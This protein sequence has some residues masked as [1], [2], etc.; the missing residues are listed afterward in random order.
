MSYVSKKKKTSKKINNK[1]LNLREFLKFSLILKS[2]ITWENVLSSLKFLKFLSFRRLE[3]LPNRCLCAHS[4]STS[5]QC[6]WPG[7]GRPVVLSCRLQF[8]FFALQTAKSNAFLSAKCCFLFLLCFIYMHSII[9]S[10]I[11][12]QLKCCS[13]FSKVINAIVNSPPNLSVPAYMHHLDIC[14]LAYCG[15][16]SLEL[17]SRGGEGREGFSMDI[18]ASLF[19]PHGITVSWLSLDKHTGPFW[20]EKLCLLGLKN[21]FLPSK[22]TVKL[23]RRGYWRRKTSE[24]KPQDTEG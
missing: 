11:K 14:F 21:S 6:Q 19:L 20:S 17:I 2:Y 15:M 22:E 7:R 9:N 1:D 23:A 24:G 16:C 10:K 13:Y 4:L 18:T 12:I 8:S 3:C 5:F